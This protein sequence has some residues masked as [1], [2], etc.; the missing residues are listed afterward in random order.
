MPKT[1][2]Q[3]KILFSQG[4]SGL[5]LE[6]GRCTSLGIREYST[7]NTTT[8]EASDVPVIANKN[9]TDQNAQVTDKLIEIFTVAYQMV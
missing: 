9:K 2:A 7:S 6:Y 8:S 4:K 3:Y 5:K 1:L